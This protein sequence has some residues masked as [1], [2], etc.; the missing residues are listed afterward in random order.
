MHLLF[1]SFY[2]SLKFDDGDAVSA[3]ALFTQA[4][5]HDIGGAFAGSCT[6]RRKMPS[7]RPWIIVTSPYPAL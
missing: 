3:L 6:S 5:F 7:P 4:L 1:L 2:L